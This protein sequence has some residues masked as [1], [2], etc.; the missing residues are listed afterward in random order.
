ML[1]CQL[2]QGLIAHGEHLIGRCEGWT[3]EMVRSRSRFKKQASHQRRYDNKG[4]GGSGTGTAQ[5]LIRPSPSSIALLPRA[6]SS[7]SWIQL[8]ICSI[9]DL[10]LF[11]QDYANICNHK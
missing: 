9:R 4:S 8:K 1:T 5:E 6:V 2:D 10:A 3:V 11:E 7:H